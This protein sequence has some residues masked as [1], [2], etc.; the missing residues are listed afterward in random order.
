MV[1]KQHRDLCG[2]CGQ[3]PVGNKK[4]KRL[5]A[6]LAYQPENLHQSVF[7]SFAEFSPDGQAI[8]YAKQHNIR[9]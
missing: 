2:T 3:S 1:E 8:L 4:R 9:V 5:V 6:I 7:Y